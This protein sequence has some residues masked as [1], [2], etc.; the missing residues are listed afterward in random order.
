ML[1]SEVE[2]QA[3]TNSEW[4]SQKVFD[5]GHFIPAG[6]PHLLHNRKNAGKRTEGQHM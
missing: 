1:I 6:Q 2:P 4:V 3:S 5:D